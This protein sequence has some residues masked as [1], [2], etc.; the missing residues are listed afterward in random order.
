MEKEMK[1]WI[2]NSDYE[3]LLKKWRF[4]I[5]GDMFFQGEI[6]KYYS[7]VMFRKRNELDSAEQ[8]RISKAVGW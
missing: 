5:A 7:N 8:V 1:N 4:A 6:G 3:S 2:D